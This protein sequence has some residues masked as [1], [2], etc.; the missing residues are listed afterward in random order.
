MTNLRL[1]DKV[2]SN[3]TKQTIIIACDKTQDVS[4]KEKAIFFIYDADK[5]STVK[6]LEKR[7]YDA[8]EKCW[9]TK[10][11]LSII[12]ENLKDYKTEVVYFFKKEKMAS[13]FMYSEEYSED[14]T[15]VLTSGI[16][17]EDKEEF[18]EDF[19]KRYN[20]SIVRGQ[21]YHYEEFGFDKD[22][23]ILKKSIN[24]K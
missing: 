12:K 8:D 4:N 20:L 10:M 24:K 13:E 22:Y 7:W 18:E 15:C 21:D 1:R 6:K 14:I 5:V 19:L 9:R 2:E 23:A 3:L 17:E 11:D 16:W